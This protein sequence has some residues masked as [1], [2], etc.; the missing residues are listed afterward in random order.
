[1]SIGIDDWKDVGKFLFGFTDANR[2][3]VWLGWLR[4]YL[5]HRY[6]VHLNICCRETIQD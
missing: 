1:M 4:R 5:F 6:C 2:G 3:L